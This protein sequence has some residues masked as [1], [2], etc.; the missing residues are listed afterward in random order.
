[1]RV[2]HQLW[3]D[4]AGFV[5]S[6]ELV[7]IATILVLGLIVGLT[8]VRDQLVQELG[9]VAA[10]I[11]DLNQTFSFSGVAGHHALTAGSF[12]Q[13]E[14]D[15]CDEVG[16]PVGAEPACIEICDADAT[17]EGTPLP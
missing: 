4:E 9:D 12:F 11:S 10:A 7:L 17:P 13:D 16:Q 5:V 3:N 15:D 1:M 2:L 8:T 14:L 6:M